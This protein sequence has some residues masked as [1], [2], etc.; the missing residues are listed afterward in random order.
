MLKDIKTAKVEPYVDKFANRPLVAVEPAAGTIVKETKKDH[1]IV[2]WELGNGVKVVFKPTNFKDDE[3]LMG[4]QSLG[5]WSVYKEK[6]DVSAQIA[7]GVAIKSGIGDFDKVELEKQL[8]GKNVYVSPYISSL[9]EGFSGRSTVDDFH[10]MLQLTYL[11]FTKPRFDKDAFNNYVKEQKDFLV[12]N[13]A[14]PDAVFGDTLRAAL[15]NYHKRFMPLTVSRYD[16]A[17]LSRVKYIFSDRFGDPSGFTFYFVGNVNPDSVKAEVLKYLGGLPTVKREE[18]FKDLGMRYP[19]T[20]L[21]VAYQRDLKTPKAT[22]FIAFTGVD[23]YDIK[24]RLMLEAI[25]E[26]LNMKMTETLREDQ[27]GTY[28]ASVF[29]RNRHYPAS[30]YFLGVYFDCN[31]A[32]LDTMVK[33]VYDEVDKLIANGPEKKKIDNIVKNKLKDYNENIKENN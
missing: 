33:I 32:K 15:Y 23:K 11:Y 18:T 22:V 6:D 10:T 14:N 12:N 24:N 28:G 3:I 19:E 9:T 20:V 4:A 17:K 8:A 25:K 1:G 26:Y 2:E 31:P 7:A 27:G 29:F 5:G 16:E 30:E 13:A 21:K